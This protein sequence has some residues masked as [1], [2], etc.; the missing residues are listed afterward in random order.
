VARFFVLLP[1]LT[2]VGALQAS[3]EIIGLGGYPV[4]PPPTTLGP[5]EMALFPPDTRPVF[6]EVST[7][8]LA[9]EQEL[10]L[11]EPV[12]HWRRGVIGWWP[13]SLAADC[14]YKPTPAE[15]TLILPPGTVA[16]DFWAKMSAFD[17]HPIIATS[18]SGVSVT[19]S[20]DTLSADYFGFYATDPGETISSITLQ[21]VPVSVYD[22]QFGHFQIAVPEPGAGLLLVAAATAGMVRR[23]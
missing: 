7:I 15:V 16:F 12:V 14:Y 23:R 22:L 13:L 19:G 5:Y 3:A 18:D 4:Y 1:L 9:F 6:T 17:G 2:W 10:T 11:S 21:G 8:P 20:S